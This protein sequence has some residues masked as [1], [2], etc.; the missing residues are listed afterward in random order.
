LNGI[1]RPRLAPLL[2]VM[3]RNAKKMKNYCVFQNQF[4]TGIAFHTLPKK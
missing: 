1:A 4:V 3:K 2:R